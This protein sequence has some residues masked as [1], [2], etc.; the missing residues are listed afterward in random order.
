MGR[1]LSSQFVLVS[2]KAII[3]LILTWT[4]F[5]AEDRTWGGHGGHHG[6]YGGGYNSN[7]YKNI[8]KYKSGNYCPSGKYMETLIRANETCPAVDTIN[9]WGSIWGVFGRNLLEETRHYGGGWGN[10]ICTFNPFNVDLSAV[11]VCS[12]CRSWWK[13]ITPLKECTISCNGN[14]V[15]CACGAQG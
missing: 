13:T 1:N 15:N 5:L 6:G 10:N 14:S 7:P 8:C 12:Y 4:I 3:L 11:K 2:M 9:P